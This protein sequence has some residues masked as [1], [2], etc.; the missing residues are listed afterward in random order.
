VTT[1]CMLRR[2]CARQAMWLHTY[3]VWCQASFH[4]QTRSSV[5]THVPPHASSHVRPGLTPLPTLSA[6]ACLTPP[7]APRVRLTGL[8]QLLQLPEE[9]ARALAA[10][11]PGLLTF[12]HADM[13]G[14]LGELGQALGMKPQEVRRLVVRRPGEEE[15]GEGG[16]GFQGG[17]VRRRGRRGGGRRVKGLREQTD[18]LGGC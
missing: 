2:L 11:E 9:Q 10:A 8:S 16:G 15:E 12:R 18:E 5:H 6:P 17:Q 3:P 7:P 13:V 4:T 1:S 14:R